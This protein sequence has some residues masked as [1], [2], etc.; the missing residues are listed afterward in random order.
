MPAAPGILPVVHSVSQGG[1]S[2]QP[3]WEVLYRT[4]LGYVSLLIFARLIGRRELNQQ[5]FSDFTSALAIG[6]VAANLSFGP[7]RATGPLLFSLALWVTLTILA[8]LAALKSRRL[9]VMLEGGPTVILHNGKILENRMR[10]LRYT[11][12]DLESMLR[13][14]GQFNIA[15][16]EFAVIEP[17][18]QLSILSK[19]QSRPVTP[20]DLNLPTRYEGLGT[21]LV[22]DGQI[23]ARNLKM[24]GLSEDWL[25]NELSRRGVSVPEVV[26]AQLDT[27]GKLYVDLRDDGGHHAAGPGGN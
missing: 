18:G 5:T 11:V 9:R 4:V 20:A 26:L 24:V 1:R 21:V 16:I 12:A 10:A 6:T 14:K 2:L 19:S 3:Y 23:R 25:R 8:D 7:Y 27:S 22:S 15:D 13:Q 17:S